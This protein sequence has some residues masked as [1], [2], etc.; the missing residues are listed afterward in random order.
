MLLLAVAAGVVRMQAWHGPIVL[1]LSA[2]H[3]V[4]AGDL[5][6]IPF[7]AL[8]IAFARSLSAGRDAGPGGWAL[9][10]SAIVLG[11]LLLAVRVFATEDGTM[12]P[13][14]G[15]TLDGTI[16]QALAD[17]A[18]PVG[19]WSNVALTYDG[20][21]QRLY[22]NGSV[23]ATHPAQGRIQTPGNP[24]WIGGNRPYGEHFDGLIDEVRVYDRALS[25][26]ELRND[27]AAPVRPAPGLVAAYAF[28][29]GSGTSAADSSGDGNTG[30][31]RGAAW[32]RGRRGDAL[33]FD[34]VATVVRVPPSSS[35]NLTT[36]MTLSGWIRPRV[37]QSGW[38]A[39][40]QRQ[41]DA[42]F[43]SASTS[44]H[45]VQGLNDTIRIALVVAAGTWFCLVIATGRGPRTAARRRS[46]WLPV[47]LFLLGSFADAAL[48]PSATL[49]GPT[50]VALW[51]AASATRSRECATFLV[52]AA[53][54]AVLTAASLSDI[55]GAGGALSFDD[56]S[57]V[58]TAAL[59]AL[60]V[61]AGAAAS[62]SSDPLRSP[63]RLRP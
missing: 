29:A 47:V 16:Q 28:D 5:L 49:I 3:G 63:A 10:A 54:F 40:V 2:G 25:P 57:V 24:L 26:S 60:F 61:L 20:T 51:L 42:Y 34:G 18:V 38:R 37:R 30:E 48:A 44:R 62:R 6:A 45:D 22:V 39:I 19:R 56:G 36:G 21:M 53:V 8:A 59:G 43:L 14:G 55:A 12:V 35:L 31:I 7:V 50:L 9:P 23:V 52:S 27:M 13:G 33:R 58:R 11:V 17:E 46:W 32:A 1:S 4:N 15:A 41:T